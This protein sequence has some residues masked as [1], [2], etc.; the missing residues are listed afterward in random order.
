MKKILATLALLVGVLHILSAVPAYPGRIRV[1]QPDG[2]AIFIR[3]HGDEWY[4]YITDDNG[5][6][7]AQAKD[8][9]YRPAEKPA[10]EEREEAVRM[11]ISAQQMRANAAAQAPSLSLGEHR[12][13][14]VLV[15]FSDRAFVIQNPATAFSNLLNQEGYSRGGATGSVRDYFVDNSHGQ[16]SPSFDV[17]GPVTLPNTGEYYAYNKTARAAEALQEACKLLDGEIDFSQ[18]DS[19]SDGKVDMILMYYAGYNQAEGGGETTIWPH[20]HFTSGEFDG[21]SLDRYFCTSELRG[22]SGSTMCGIGNTAHEFSHSLGLPDFYDT[23]YEDNGQAGG[24]YSFST[25]CD[26]CYN[27]NA[28]TPP[29]FNSE[30]LRLLGW[31]G[32]QTEI[33]AQG[34]LTIDPIQDYVAYRSPRRWKVSISSMSAGP[35]RVGT[36]IFPAPEC[37]SIMWTN[38]TGKA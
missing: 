8:G 6:V 32:E 11:R 26:G 19:N 4:H 23:D 25:M 21:V 36:A 12:I 22:N 37:W 30:E 2:S 38:P 34:E 14:V 16:Y 35:R 15:D 29:Y 18:Y 10:R 28:R 5:Q 27:N 17:Y 1:I 3:I 33:D 24:L 7:I 20:Q 9:F 13:P 31:M